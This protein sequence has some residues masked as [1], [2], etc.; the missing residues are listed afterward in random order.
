MFT[1]GAA[2]SGGRETSQLR[3]GKNPA[4]QSMGLGFRIEV[5]WFKLQSKTESCF[6]L[7]HI[8]KDTSRDHPGLQSKTENNKVK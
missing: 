6:Y 2:R 3:R 4:C 1:S 7:I 5:F 8:F